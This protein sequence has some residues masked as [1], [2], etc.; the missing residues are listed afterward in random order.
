ILDQDGNIS[1]A[2]YAKIYGPI[3]YGDDEKGG[4]IVRFTYFFNPTPNDRNME[5]DRNHNLMTK[6]GRGTIYQP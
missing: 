2:R 6:T 3:E 1:S 4:G 5:F